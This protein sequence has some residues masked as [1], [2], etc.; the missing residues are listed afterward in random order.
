MGE[1][2]R[3]LVERKNDWGQKSVV[4]AIRLPNNRIV[5]IEALSLSAA[6]LVPSLAHIA[7]IDLSFNEIELVDKDILNFPT[8]TTLYLHANRI[9]ALAE[10]DKLAALPRLRTL[11]L[12]GNPV[13][14][15]GRAYRQYVIA[16]IPT[17]RH[18][19]FCAIT[20]QDRPWKKGGGNG[21][22]VG[23]GAGGVLGLGRGGRGGAAAA[24]V[25]E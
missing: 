20:K 12:H 8:L 13:E 6:K 4:T 15:A 9:A 21:A 22:A 18:L 7:W 14:N 19:D 1:I 3:A 10:L 5:S 16:R 17:L 2:K 25:A 23:A 11:T 24:E